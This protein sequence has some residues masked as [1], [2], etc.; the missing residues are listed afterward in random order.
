MRIKFLPKF[1]T[2]AAAAAVLLGGV[3]SA[4]AAHPDV[5]LFTF[6]EIATQYGMPAMPVMI[7]NTTSM[8]GMPFSPKQSCG[9]ANCHDYDSISDH[10]FHSAQGMFEWKDTPD[11]EFLPMEQ[12]VKPW[13]QGTAMYGKW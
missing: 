1:L 3:G 13:T 10:A 5:Q 12:N 2:A 6:E 7:M 11:G 8:Q 4:Q 9:T